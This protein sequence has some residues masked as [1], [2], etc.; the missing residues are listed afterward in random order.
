VGYIISW[1]RFC[2]MADKKSGYAILFLEKF[3]M[4]NK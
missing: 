3:T 4:G 1:Y 2:R